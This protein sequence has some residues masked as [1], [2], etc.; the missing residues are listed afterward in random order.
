MNQL[1]QSAL[2]LLVSTGAMLGLTLPFGKIAASLHISPFMWAFVISAGAGLILLGFL[3][4]R[5]R[6]LNFSTH[7]LRYYFIAAAVS[8]A[9][10]NVMVLSVIPHLG[11]GFT[12]IMYT[13]SPV[14]TL[15]LSVVCGLKRPNSLGVIG[16]AVGFLGALLVAIT[17][18][19]T[20]S[21]AEPLWLIVALL[22][23]VV[24]AVGNVYR[25]IDWPK[26]ADPV[27]LACGSHLAAAL[28][29]IISMLFVDGDFP[30][31]QLMAAPWMVFIQAVV[32][33]LMFTLY[34]QLQIVGG[35]VYL[36]QMGYVAAAIGLISGTLFM[37]EHYQMLTWFGALVIAL[38][39]F[40]TTKAQSAK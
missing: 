19:E 6:F 27:E 16:I 38:G 11:A 15:L 1:M 22:I 25:T 32:S 35:P 26:N 34:F 23:P 10:P 40:F 2:F 17:R 7:H 37:G 18:G 14:T 20:G 30:I 28:L 12:G 31:S 3:L 5:A 13:L 39:V 21:V 8:Y 4:A 29:L 9:L 36:S 24:L 33:A